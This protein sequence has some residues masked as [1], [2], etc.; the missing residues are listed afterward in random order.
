MEK[1]NALWRQIRDFAW[2]RRAFI[3]VAAVS[4]VAG[5]GLAAVYATA[6]D[7]TETLAFCAHSCHEMESTVYTEYT[8]TA[9]FRNP[10]GVMVTCADC[11]IPKGNWVAAMGTKIAATREIWG[12]VVGGE[13]DLKVFNA[14]RP[15][16]EK[17]VLAGFA[18]TN[19]RA[20]KS[21]HVYAN[22]VL[23]DQNPA[24]RAMH[25]RAMKT[26]ANCLECHQEVAHPRGEQASMI[27]AA[28]PMTQS[29][30]ANGE[31]IYNKSCAACHNSMEPK[32]ADRAA[33]APLL[34]EGDQALIDATIHGKGIMPA[35][36]GDASL[37]DTDI[38][39]AVE[40]MT[41][42]AR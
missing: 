3:A 8:H 16:L 12:H 20:C 23:A 1:L 22:M 4:M 41:S 33:W 15:D 39:A 21:C 11:H 34:R 14:R 29:Q 32:L 36:G 40:Y 38:R 7:H 30:A 25:T 19:A 42:K 10:Q 24:A 9:H 6:V 2:S 5:L 28:Q 27:E 17:A 37:S 31:A 13:S 18:A 26:D 35:R